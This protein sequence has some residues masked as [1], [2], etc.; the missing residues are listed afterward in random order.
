MDA[1]WPKAS[2]E[3]PRF[4]HRL[5]SWGAALAFGVF[6]LLPLDYAS[7]LGGALARHI[8]PHLGIAKRARHNISRAFPQLSE[9]EIARIVAG[10]WDNLGRVAGE[11]PHLR[12]IRVFEPGGRI[13]TRGLEHIDRAVAAG[14][15]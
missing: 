13:E 12:K 5:E 7:A 2:A 10:M 15:Q 6:G 4:T 1:T 14:R 9:D 3:A 11:Y 8:G